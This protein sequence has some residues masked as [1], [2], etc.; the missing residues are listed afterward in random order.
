MKNQDS[1]LKRFYRLNI[2]LFII[3]IAVLVIWL[4]TTESRF[5]DKKMKINSNEFLQEELKLNEAQFDSIISLDKINFLHYQRVLRKLS[6]NRKKL[7]AEVLKAEPDKAEIKELTRIIGHLNTALNRQTVNH[8]FN[9]KKVCNEDQQEKL[10]ILFGDIL[11]V[12][13]Y[14][15]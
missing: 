8:L 14:A 15:D 2:L 1:N 12:N 13:E 10:R 7:L 9:I 5:I 4:M 6:E 3:N 11:E